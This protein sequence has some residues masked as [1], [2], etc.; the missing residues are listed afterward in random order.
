MAFYKNQKSATNK[1][2]KGRLSNLQCK[3]T[4]LRFDRKLNISS[5][6]GFSF[7]DQVEESSTGK[8]YALKR[9]QCHSTAEEKAAEEEAK[10]HQL[11]DSPYL[12][13]VEAWSKKKLS[14]DD[15][16]VLLILPYFKVL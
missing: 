5:C 10:F 14:G 7:V 16:E 11:F 9:I 12:I 6:R 13:C 3:Q 4:E 2:Y 1:E 8:K 15:S